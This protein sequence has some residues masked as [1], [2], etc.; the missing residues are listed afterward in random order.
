[1]QSMWKKITHASVLYAALTCFNTALPIVTHLNYRS[2][3]VDAARELSGWT[4]QVNLPYQD[5]WYGSFSVTP[6]Y[7]S[8]FN[9]KQIAKNL[10]GSENIKISG[11]HVANR[12]EN[13]W[14]AEYFY[15]PTDFQSSL[16]FNPSITNAIVD[17]DLY[18]GLNG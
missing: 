14:L 1:M 17:L 12:G 15:L 3:A 10:F 16:N 18:L 9:S 2:Q 6:E 11:S 7:T 8:S 5:C 4:Q 13:D